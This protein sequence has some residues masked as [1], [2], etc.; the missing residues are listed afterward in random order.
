MFQD[1]EQ[2]CGLAAL[3]MRCVLVRM[4][5]MDLLA[6]FAVLH[7]QQGTPGMCTVYVSCAI[8]IPELLQRSTHA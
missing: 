4:H 3:L 2:L 6:L 1:P 5:G 7:L 8:A